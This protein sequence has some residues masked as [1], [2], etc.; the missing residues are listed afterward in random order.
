VERN[1]SRCDRFE[2]AWLAGDRPRPAEFLAGVEG[3]EREDLLGKL[4]R[5]LAD[6]LPR[7]QR[8]R[9]LAG[10]RVSVRE[11]L[12]EMPELRQVPEVVFG[13]VCQEVILREELHDAA[14]RAEDYLDLLPGHDA[15]LRRFFADR[16]P[17][18]RPRP[19]A[20]PLDRYQV[21]D[22]IGRGGMGDVFWVHDPHLGRDLALKVLR[23]DRREPHLVRRFL[24]EARLHSRLQH[25]GVAPVHDLGEAADGR[26]YFTMKL[27]KGHTLA[28]L[29]TGR[30][31]PAEDLPRF[32]S[33]FEQVCQAV[34]YAHAQG[35]LHRDLKPHNVMVGA[36]GEVQVMDWGLA[37]EMRRAPPSEAS[38]A[39][40]EAATTESALGDTV[41][42]GHGTQPGEVM[43]TPAYMAPEQARAEWGQVDERADVFAVGAILCEVLTGRP[44][45]TG[46]N[47]EDILRRARCGE[48]AEALGRLGQC[49]A[50]AALAGLCRECLAAEC[51]GRPC[52]AGVVA[53]RV[54]AYQ[55][56]V[57]E[58]LRRAE[59]ERARAEVQARE[60]RRR[61]RLA[62]VLGGVVMLLLAGGGGGVW[63]QQRQQEK[64]DLA[65]SNGLARAEL[66]AEQARADPL[67]PEKYQQALEAARVAAQ[68]AEGASADASQR[69][70]DLVARLGQEAEAARKDRALLAALLD[71]RGPRKGPKYQSDAR[72]AMMALA[73]P[74]ADEQ[75][76]AAFRAG[77]LDVDNTPPAEAAALLKARPPAVVTEVIAALDE[78]ASERRRQGK[79]K[80]EWQRLADLAALLDEEPGS[81]RRELRE[82]LARGR[83]PLER[84]LSVL[85]AA[86]RPVPV[87]VEVPLG[88][89]HLRLRQ[90]AEATDAATEPVLGL[91][92]LVRALFVAGEEARAEQLLRAAIGARP[93]EVV[94]YYM[95]GELLTH[96]EPPRWAEAV[97]CYQAA[98][99][100]RPDLGV[101]LAEALLRSG[102]GREG[103]A[104]LALLVSDTPGNPYLHSQY[105][106]AL[107]DKGRLDEAIDE[108]RQAIALDPKDARAHNNLGGALRK[109]GRWD[110]A[111]AEFRQAIAL[112]PK[113]AGAHY[114]LGA[115][116]RE[117][118]RLAEAM[119]EYHQAI[120]L[121]PKLALAHNGLGN[122]LYA[123]KRWDEAMEEYRQAIAL[124]PKLALAHDNLGNA[125]HAKGRL[126]EAM[127]EWRQAIDIDPKDAQ[128]HYKLGN[129]LAEKRRLDEA[130]DEFRQAIDIDPK[131]AQAHTG[132]GVVLAA[133][134]RLDEAVAEYRRAI[135]LDPKLA[136][137][138]YNLGLAL[139]RKERLDEALTE[140]RQAV[141]L[142]PDCAEAHCN[143]GLVLQQQGRF[144]EALA[145]LRR[146]HELG[147]KQPGWRYPSSQWV[148]NAERLLALDT[149]LPAILTGEAAA[150]N[151]GEAIALAEMCRQPYQKRYAASA[152]LYA[153]AFGAEPRLAAD[154]N[155]QHRYNAA[156]SAALA[157]A[158]Q[159]EDA[160]LLPDRVAAMFR[161]W[162]LG[163]LREDLKAYA[164]LV[165]Q[166]NPAGR[167]AVRQRLL[168]WQKDPDLAGLRDK[169][170]LAKLP[171]AERDAC[172]RLWADVDAL[173]QRTQEK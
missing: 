52:H 85:S 63:W 12:R 29:L 10:E 102:R 168:H 7:E 11:Y 134:G 121:D 20:P 158:G 130:L 122:T 147:S 120:A 13:L 50:D 124:D 61:R 74:T 114:N 112:D 31:G 18:P 65:V 127:A 75:F 25:P 145:C 14:A 30:A 6:Y 51:E 55:A 151:L 100:L 23:K 2:S 81:K 58:R 138:H 32:L 109:T 106:A 93:R 123:R 83:L 137:P 152:R 56:E 107:Y 117:K 172:R 78:W 37:K 105:A 45:Y 108:L 38:A 99:A 59:L 88:P 67:Q 166:T 57:Q 79:P 118:G 43:G 87:P 22:F 135:A 72:G 98:R 171:E 47:T 1:D 155:A 90:L 132:L 160:H 86:L 157:A 111:L 26:P 71:V 113:Y 9:W 104:L 142:K 15:P 144:D 33:I 159:G 150:A 146:G 42:E 170:A 148:R 64:A 96:Q 3:P 101:N 4:L 28:E 92:T 103:L 68:L 77:G 5:L 133:K 48:L 163:W 141:R 35:V 73:E 17:S 40:R 62:L 161:G 27:V 115:A 80:A 16:Q 167:Q 131:H 136:E 165:G 41:D 154:L 97:E 8:H 149:K 162:A 169:D 69:A 84:A 91:M 110:E 19:A 82:I 119:D 153:D 125:L 39:A 46:R 60:E 139:H 44:P 164:G 173:L 89:D 95:L 54:A 140:Y 143:L 128:P 66:L 76:A 129:A 126:D 36:F 94:L 116:L 24:E 21:S 70:K 49:G 34:A 53:K 156:C